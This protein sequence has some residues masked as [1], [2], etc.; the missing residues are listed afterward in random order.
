M[1]VLVLNTTV[2]IPTGGDGFINLSG[3]LYLL[4][5]P[6]LIFFERSFHEIC[7]KRISVD[8]AY[9]ATDTS[10]RAV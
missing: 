7:V 10:I 8:G 5:L 1:A 3:F 9:K 4:S 6:T 2:Q